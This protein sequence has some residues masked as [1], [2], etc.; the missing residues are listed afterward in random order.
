MIDVY[1]GQGRN[2]EAYKCYQRMK[3]EGLSP[4]KVT[5]VSLLNAF[6][7]PGLLRQ[8]QEV[9]AE[10]IKAGLESDPRVATSL[11]SMYVKCGNILAAQEVFNKWQTGTLS[12][13]T[14]LIA[15]YAQQGENKVAYELLQKMP[16]TKQDHFCVCS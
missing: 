10:I 16:N 11:V 9:H 1:V 14:G 12:P 6:S 7:N 8:G 13:W 2:V 5:F 3:E 4:D 15:D